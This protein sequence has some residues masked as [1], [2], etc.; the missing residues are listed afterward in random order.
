[1]LP[2]VEQQ[3]QQ[4]QQQAALAVFG[5][6]AMKEAPGGGAWAEMGTH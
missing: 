2:V 6:S 1:V 3:Q 5:K 4:Q